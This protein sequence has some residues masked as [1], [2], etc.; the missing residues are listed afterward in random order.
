MRARASDD[1]FAGFQR[2]STWPEH[3]PPAFL[4]AGIG[5]QSPRA[6][7]PLVRFTRDQNLFDIDASRIADTWVLKSIIGGAVVYDRSTQGNEDIED[8]EDMPPREIH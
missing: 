6:K 4:H 7:R 3:P 2:G 8:L 5:T 1:S